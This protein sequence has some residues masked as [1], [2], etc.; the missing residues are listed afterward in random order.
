MCAVTQL[1]Q[2]QQIIK[3]YPGV[4]VDFWGAH[5]P[6]CLRIKP[7]FEAA[8]QAN[9]NP[10]LVFVAVNTKEGQQCAQAFNVTGIPNFIAFLNGNQYKNFKGANEQMLFAT[11][12]ELAE[13]IPKGTVTAKT[14]DQIAFKLFKPTSMAPSLYNTMA[15][16]DKMK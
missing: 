12:G 11:I 8:A 14:H 1:P 7:T 5:C 4:I 6:P 15:N 16:V 13:K 3:E 9:N 10:N 2:L